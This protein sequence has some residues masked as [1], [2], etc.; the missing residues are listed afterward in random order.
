MARTRDK[1]FSNGL[2]EGKWPV[3]TECIHSHTRP[4]L[5]Y[6]PQLDCAC[7]CHP[8]CPPNLQHPRLSSIAVAKSGEAEASC[9]LR[10]P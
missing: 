1:Y 7:K 6:L 10:D 9:A 3:F 2:Y 8:W 5:V 4:L